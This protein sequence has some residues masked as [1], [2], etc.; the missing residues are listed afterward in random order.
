[1]KSFVIAMLIANALLGLFFL[2]LGHRQAALVNLA[3]AVVLVVLLV[4]YEREDR[5][6]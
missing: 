4:K 6:S 1:M 5:N 2:G 3:V